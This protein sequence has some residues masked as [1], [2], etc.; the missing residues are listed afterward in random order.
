MTNMDPQ[1][2]PTKPAR[3]SKQ[4]NP[5]TRF[6]HAILELLES[7]PPEAPAWVA[8][9]ELIHEVPDLT[10]EI[11]A[12]ALS[13]S[14]AKSRVIVIRPPALDSPVILKEKL[15]VCAADRRFLQWLTEQYCT[16]E[17]PVVSLGE[18]T[19]GL[20][21]RLKKLVEAYWPLHREQ[22]PVGLTPK[23]LQY[24]RK[25]L[26]AIHDQRF[27]LPEEELSQKLVEAL[28]TQKQSGGD[29]YPA[30][31]ETLASLAG[32]LI[33]NRLLQQAAS[34]PPFTNH[35]RELTEGPNPLHAFIGDVSDILLTDAFLRQLVQATCTAALPEV[36]LSVLAKQVSRDLR[37]S[38]VD[39]WLKQAAQRQDL[40]FGTL[41]SAA[42]KKKTDVLIRDKR[43]P[44]PELALAEEFVRYVAKR[45]AIGERAYPV[46]LRQLLDANAS[47]TTTTIRNKALQSE[48][49][50]SQVTI[51]LAEVADAEVVL[52]GD[53]EQ[54]GRSPAL[55]LATLRSLRSHD[56]H[57]VAIDK[58]VSYKSLH[59]AV[60]TSLK[61]HVEEAIANHSLP[62]GIGAISISKKWSLLLL[63]DVVGATAEPPAA[64][65]LPVPSSTPSQA[66]DRD[67]SRFAEDF[68]AAFARLDGKLG[69][70]HYASLVD[71]RPALP[72]YPRD[73]FDRELLNLR[74]A[75]KYSLSLVEGRFGLTDEEQ[76]ACLIVDH[77]PHLL[78]QK[79]SNGSHTH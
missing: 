15:D 34:I 7:R 78:V 19:Q 60:R 59:P 52:R 16:A 69:L 1:S 18:L 38:F 28:H 30:G 42:T 12:E 64:V 32:S 74:R 29:G 37:P 27:A 63:D 54:L 43:F 10:A 17:T 49:F 9:S 20:D 66:P 46:P 22:L 39:G 51:S 4:A 11:V 21:K 70:P 6:A 26:F 50:R 24:G 77:V 41:H 71:L 55:L 2:N 57:A 61:L 65:N 56:N 13:T 58:L 75:G 62:R 33:D 67:G 40:G 45:K 73:I 53:E 68:D 14:P 72:Q 47:Y 3:K 23:L 25:K 48:L 8:G 76:Q 36:K 31:W 79:K 35:A 5:A 44:P